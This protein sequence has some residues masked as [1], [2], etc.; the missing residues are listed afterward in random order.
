MLA[1]LL[2]GFHHLGNLNERQIKIL[3]DTKRNAPDDV[4]FDKFFLDFFTS[5]DAFHN[6]LVKKNDRLQERPTKGI[7]KETPRGTEKGSDRT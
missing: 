2:D 3:K 5:K 4:D 1:R 6:F 7:I